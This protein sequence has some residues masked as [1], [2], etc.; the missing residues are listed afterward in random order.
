MHRPLH[1]SPLE[2]DPQAVP[3][4]LAVAVLAV[5]SA[6]RRM[7]RATADE[8]LRD[9]TTVAPRRHLPPCLRS[10]SA[11]TAPRAAHTPTP[12]VILRGRVAGSSSS[13]PPTGAT[14]ISVIYDQARSREIV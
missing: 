9:G 11:P 2:R 12:F 5:H 8:A 1:G 6:A 13:Y 7:G 4:A 3:V 14:R 10:A